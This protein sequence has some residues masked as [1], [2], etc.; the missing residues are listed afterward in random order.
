MKIILAILLIIIMIILAIIISILA[1]YKE[2]IWKC[3]E[4][5]EEND[6]DKK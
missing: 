1:E 3:I 6:N 2:E 4:F 5:K